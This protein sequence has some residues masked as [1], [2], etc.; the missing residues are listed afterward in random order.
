LQNRTW[1]SQCLSH[2]AAAKAHLLTGPLVVVQLRFQQCNLKLPSRR[3]AP[4]H[5]HQIILFLFIL[6]LCEPHQSGAAKSAVPPLACTSITLL[7]S[8]ASIGVTSLSYRDS[9]CFV[10][11][12]ASGR[13]ALWLVRGAACRRPIDWLLKVHAPLW[14]GL[15]FYLRRTMSLAGITHAVHQ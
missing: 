6:R 9:G 8:V 10:L 5:A 14:S 3:S 11:Q 13:A 1:L 7:S 12:S 4:R 2:G 15:F